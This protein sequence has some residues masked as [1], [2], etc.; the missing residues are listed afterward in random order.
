MSYFSTREFREQE[1]RE[2]LG[3]KKA[4]ETVVAIK[5]DIARGSVDSTVNKQ[6]ATKTEEDHIPNY[7]KWWQIFFR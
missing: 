6:E 5:D 4:D 7:R 1:A 2:K 3:L